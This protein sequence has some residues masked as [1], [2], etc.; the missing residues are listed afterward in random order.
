MGSAPGVL[1]ERPQLRRARVAGG[2]RAFHPGHRDL[3]PVR[4]Q[5]IRHLAA[6]TERCRESIF[7]TDKG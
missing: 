1:P 3:R 2:N 6:L 5:S 7:L 4:K